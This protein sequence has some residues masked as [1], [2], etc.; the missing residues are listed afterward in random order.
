MSV[1]WD[2]VRGLRH[3]FQYLLATPINVKDGTLKTVLSLQA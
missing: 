1:L 2:D 3:S